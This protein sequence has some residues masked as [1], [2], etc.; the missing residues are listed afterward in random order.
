MTLMQLAK[1]CGRNALVLKEFKIEEGGPCYV[2]IRGRKSGFF[3]WLKS[4]IG[5]AD[6]TSVQV[7]DDRL[8]Y[9]DVSGAGTFVETIP[10]SAVS[11]LG[12]GYLRPIM[13]LIKG[14]AFVVIGIVLS[15]YSLQYGQVAGIAAKVLWVLAVVEFICYFFRKTLIMYFIP[16]SGTVLSISFKRSLIEGVSVGREEANKATELIS[17]LV[18]RNTQA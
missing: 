17:S 11:N 5:L 6:V 10:L 14:F 16:A 13:S 18:R 9:S 3:N 2:R 4:I 1:I 12:T 15:V 8:E 7:F